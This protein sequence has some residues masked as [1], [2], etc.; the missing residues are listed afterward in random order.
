MRGVCL[1]VCSRFRQ[2]A[3]VYAVFERTMLS[4]CALLDIVQT[5]SIDTRPSSGSH[6]WLRSTFSPVCVCDVRRITNALVAAVC[7]RRCRYRALYAGCSI[8]Q[9]SHPH[10]SCNT[11][12]FSVC[13]CVLLHCALCEL[14]AAATFTHACVYITSKNVSVLC[15]AARVCACDMRAFC[16]ADGDVMQSSS[17]CFATEHFALGSTTGR[18]VFLAHRHCCASVM[19]VYSTECVMI[20]QEIQKRTCGNTRLTHNNELL[21]MAAESKTFCASRRHHANPRFAW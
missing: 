12:F 21:Q 16:A 8:T 13:G 18:G 9:N 2:S 20:V 5:L 15:K 1:C 19:C 10:A 3:S 11:V 6:V 14:Y 7:G 4:L 17:E